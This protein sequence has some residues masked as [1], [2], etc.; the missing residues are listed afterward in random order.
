MITAKQRKCLAFI[1]REIRDSGVCPS[2]H[3]IAAHMGIS[4][5]E[6]VQRYLKSLEERNAISRIPKKARSIEVTQKGMDILKTG[7]KAADEALSQKIRAN[8]NSDDREANG[9]TLN[10]IIINHLNEIG[11]TET[12]EAYFLANT[13]RA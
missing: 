10:E 8:C 5:K 11:Y 3:E 7:V 2:Y 9:V 1:D 13:W 6:N 4:S 12:A